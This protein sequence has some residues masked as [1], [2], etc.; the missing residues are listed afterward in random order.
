MSQ[1]LASAVTRGEKIDDW[2]S[3]KRQ[4]SLS[5][6]R[7]AQW[8]TR[9]TEAWKYT[10]VK[11]IESAKLSD[12]FNE[13]A[14]NNTD[15]IANEKITSLDSID[16]VFYNGQLQTDLDAL[17]LP[18]GLTIQS[19]NQPSSDAQLWG[20]DTFA[21][22]KPERHL[23]GLVNDVLAQQ[24]LLID[25]ANDVVVRSAIRIVHSFSEGQEAHHRVLVRL[26][27]NSK[28]TVIEQFTGNV[29]SFNTGFAEFQLSEQAEL[30]H[31]RFALQ[32]GAA[33]SVG[34]SHFN[35]ATKA[36]L[37]STLIGFGSDLSRV[38]IDVTHAGEF[39]YAKLNAIYLLDGKE[40]FDL[41]STIEHVAANG[42]TEENVRGIVA[43][44][45]RAVFNGRIHIHRGAQK[46]LAELNNRNLLMSDKAEINT[47]PEL[48]I[49]ADDVRCA[50]GATIAELDKK[51]LYYMQSRGIS[52]GQAQIMLNFGFINELVDQMPN[53]AL[54]EWLRPQLRERF[55]Q[56]DVQ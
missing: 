41:H 14:V 38:D 8:P 44:R 23:F 7:Q 35:L 56:M 20:L 28:T 10:P 9:K 6:L 36:K 40:L 39:C 21:V 31:Y 15:A 49:Y 51:S 24:G 46:T 55:A 18:V 47:K 12:G 29:A 50:H 27:E 52:R 48:E 5:L 30:E 19:L 13:V 42:T 53:E 37:N 34:G 16:L 25:I 26:G 54:A 2:L 1:W 3:V 45:S 43:D 22:I 33:I 32:T 11:A 4:A 17:D